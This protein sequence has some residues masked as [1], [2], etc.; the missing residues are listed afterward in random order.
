MTSVLLIL[1]TS[2]LSGKPFALEAS[3]LLQMPAP[4]AASPA[5][6]SQRPT[7]APE[8]SSAAVHLPLRPSQPNSGLSSRSSC[9]CLLTIAF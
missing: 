4:S 7:S 6:P 1:L 8:A 5:Q 9:E 3:A 2:C